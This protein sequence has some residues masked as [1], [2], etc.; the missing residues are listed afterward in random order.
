MRVIVT[1]DD[2]YGVAFNERRQSRDR[3]LCAD[4]V[5]SLGS[6]DTL[7]LSS[8]SLPLFNEA[9]AKIRVSENPA[10]DLADNEIAFLERTSI[11]PLLDQ[12]TE[13]TVY[14]WNRRYP[15]DVSLGVVPSDS[16]F[17]LCEKSEFVGSSH[18]KIIK[19]IYRR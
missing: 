1:V 13:L 5:R 10:C 6:E 14:H 2:A 19:E 15:Q 8:Y 3:I 17:A 4:I 12:I 16:G 9:E 11:L 7:V 18:D